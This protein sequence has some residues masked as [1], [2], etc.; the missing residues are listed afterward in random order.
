MYTPLTIS[1]SVRRAQ[2]SA[3]RFVRKVFVLVGQPVLRTRA[4]QVP[5]AVLT[6]VAMIFLLQRHADVR[7]CTEFVPLDYRTGLA[8]FVAGIKKP[9]N[10]RL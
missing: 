8:V 6:R 9:R 4:F 10:A 2:S 3:S 1:S 7:H 5:A